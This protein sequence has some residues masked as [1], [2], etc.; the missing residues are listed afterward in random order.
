MGRGKILTKEQQA[1]IL[2]MHRRQKASPKAISIEIDK[3]LT[4]VKNFLRSPETY[5]K[6][7]YALKRRKITEREVKCLI[8]E[9]IKSE[10]SSAQLVKIQKLN[11][12]A[13]HVRGLLKNP[14]N[15]VFKK[16][17]T[18]PKLTKRHRVARVTF[19]IEWLGKILQ[20]RKCIFSDYKKWTLDGPLGL[21]KCWQLKGAPPKECMRRNMEGGSVMMW[22]GFSIKGTTALA[23]VESTQKAA[24]HVETLENHLLPHLHEHFLKRGAIDAWFQQ[25]NASIHTAKL[26]QN[27]L[28]QLKLKTMNWPALSPDLNPMENL[29]GILVQRVY[30]GGTKQYHDK[31]ALK[32]G[33]QKAWDSIDQD[34]IKSLLDSMKSRFEECIRLKGMKTK[35]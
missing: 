21:Q 17:K 1:T 33:I 22:G 5:G 3:S 8:R 35:Y 14:G 24:D 32:A 15:L 25:D 11:I 6:R 4:V 30:E 16:K 12:S 10:C 18:S 9:A 23:F 20:I 13:R 7:S 2:Y 29:W 31:K 34:T 28:K 27:W 19:S 26:T